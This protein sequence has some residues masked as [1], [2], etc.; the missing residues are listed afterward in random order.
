M[1]RFEPDYNPYHHRNVLTGLATCLETLPAE[2]LNGTWG[3]EHDAELSTCL[4]D[5]FE[6]G[7]QFSNGFWS[8][9]VNRWGA[10]KTKPPEYDLA[11]AE[12]A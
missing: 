7:I 12:T 1:I 4:D 10:F 8:D 6:S 5:V 3:P 9:Y 2:K 11:P